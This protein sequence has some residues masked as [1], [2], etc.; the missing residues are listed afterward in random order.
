MVQGL[1]GLRISAG[2]LTVR[3]YCVRRV[4][5]KHSS[6]IFVWAGT[7]VR[8]FFV[9]DEVVDAISCIASAS[10]RSGEVPSSV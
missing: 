10:Q 6:Y 2:A 1:D 7:V 4:Q 8:S 3:R 5:W 9:F